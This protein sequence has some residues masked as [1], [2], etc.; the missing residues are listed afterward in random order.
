MSSLKDS[1]PSETKWKHFFVMVV[2]STFIFAAIFT[3][4]PTLVIHP[5]V[6]MG[7][8]HRAQYIRTTVIKALPEHILTE[9]GRSD[10]DLRFIVLMCMLMKF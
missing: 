5:V 2:M 10:E 4:R 7:V 3:M 8:L 9:E 6:A 1:K